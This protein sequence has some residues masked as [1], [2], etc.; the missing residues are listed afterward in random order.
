MLNLSRQ[1]ARLIKENYG[2]ARKFLEQPIPGFPQFADQLTDEQLSMSGNHRDEFIKKKYKA[3]PKPKQAPPKFNSE[4]KEFVPK[5]KEE[6]KK[7]EPR[8][9]EK[10]VSVAKTEEVKP[11]VIQP[12]KEE[13]PKLVYQPKQQPTPVAVAEV[14]GP[15]SELKPLEPAAIISTAS[16][17]GG[18]FG[19][20]PSFKVLDP[21]LVNQPKWQKIIQGGSQPAK[22]EKQE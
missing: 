13:K 18:M 5:K 2:A 17:Q 11:K 14:E 20:M 6:Q 7:Q 15:Q 21:E 3:E 8:K 19:A 4:A 1:F 12:K 16:V 9:H 10:Y 22:N